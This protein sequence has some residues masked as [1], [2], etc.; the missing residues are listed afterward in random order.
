MSGKEIPYTLKAYHAWLGVQKIYYHTYSSGNILKVLPENE[1]PP[2]SIYT[3]LPKKFCFSKTDE[4]PPFLQA[5]IDMLEEK[6]KKRVKFYCLSFT[7]F[8]WDIR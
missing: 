8:L 5:T 4:I 2:K 3:Q 1:A 6:K 7:S